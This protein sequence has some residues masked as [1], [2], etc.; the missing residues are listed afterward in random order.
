MC[1]KT[2]IQSAINEAKHYGWWNNDNNSVVGIKIP[3]TANVYFENDD[4]LYG[5]DST[6]F[7]LWSDNKPEELEEL[8][9]DFCDENGFDKNSVYA[10]ELVKCKEWESAAF[11][12]IVG[13][14]VCEAI[15]DVA[16]E[17]NEYFTGD[18]SV[19]G[20]FI[21][22]EGYRSGILPKMRDLM[23]EWLELDK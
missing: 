7:D 1:D 8:W 16:R 19:I 3:S 4:S 18:D 14:F 20:C 23:I 10:V 17:I 22:G 12:S 2:K 6:Q 13:D 9:N 21:E 15:V 5:T 11:D